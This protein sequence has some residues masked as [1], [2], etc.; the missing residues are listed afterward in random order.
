MSSTSQNFFAQRFFYMLIGKID[1][2]LS[3]RILELLHS[4]TILWTRGPVNESIDTQEYSNPT[5]FTYTMLETPFTDIQT[6]RFDIVYELWQTIY[7]THPSEFKSFVS[8]DRIKCNL[9]TRSAD[10]RSHIPHV[11]R[12]TPHR[13]ILYYA[14]TSDG[15]SRF[16]TDSGVVSVSPEQGKYVIF[17]GDLTHASSS[18][19][20]HDERLVVNFNFSVAKYFKGEDHA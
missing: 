9:L 2:S 15:L 12:Y 17:D 7:R 11:D 13:V 14:N 16:W 3:N 18:P 20:E 10:A 1:S 19:L 8:L 6:S 4:D 5:Q